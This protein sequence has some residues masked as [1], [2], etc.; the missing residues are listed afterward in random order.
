[1][2]VWLHRR[3]AGDTDRGIA[4]RD[5]AVREAAVSG[6]LGHLGPAWPGMI[7]KT[8]TGPD[9]LRAPKWTAIE[10]IGHTRRLTGPLG[11]KRRRR[12]VLS[13][14]QLSAWWKSVTGQTAEGRDNQC[15]IK[16]FAEGQQV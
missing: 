6:R 15:D 13:S 16:P 2:A 1:M 7:A 9:V 5:P 3:V 10:V 4:G 12:A 14:H 11:T 8:G